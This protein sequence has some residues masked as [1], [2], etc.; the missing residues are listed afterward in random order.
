MAKL[1]PK[2]KIS[3]EEKKKLLLLFLR[4]FRWNV[5]VQFYLQQTFWSFGNCMLRSQKGGVETY[6][7][8]QNSAYTC[9]FMLPYINQDFAVL[10][11]ASIQ[12]KNSVSNEFLN[13]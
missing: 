11:R 3:G 1:F 6:C 10:Q 4:K 5:E 8:M 7:Y 13:R 9:M 2:M 12:T